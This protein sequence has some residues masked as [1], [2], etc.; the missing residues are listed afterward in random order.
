MS[1]IVSIGTAVP[2]CKHDQSRILEFMQQVYALNA[3]EQRKVKFLYRQSGISTRY[4]VIPDYSLEARDW[5]FY[6]PSENLEPFPSLEKRMQRYSQYAAALSLKAVQQCTASHPDQKIT[7]LITVS[8]TGMSAPGLDLELME[9]LNLPATTFRSSV[10]FMGC[11]AA[12]HALKIADA[13]C[14]ADAAANVLIVCTELCTLHFQNEP[15][16]DNITSS[17]LFADGAAAVLVSGNKELEGLTIANFYSKVALKGKKDMA[18]EL[19]SKGFLMTL[20][21]YIPEIIGADFNELVTEAVAAAGLQ[22]DDISH[23]CIHPGGKKILEAVHKSLGFTNGQL[24]P[25]YDILRDYGNMSSATLLFV[26][27]KIMGELKKEE[28]PTI[29]GAA[30]GPGLTMETIILSA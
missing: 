10:N 4:S 22:K 30:F 12:V 17:M 2:E 16:I 9:L 7:H 11:Y 25:C 27:Q 26:L 5:E 28:Q 20:S 3:E 21:S 6:S 14:K 24:Q 29:F 18:W 15:T 8:C 23:W 19:S 13:F 1:K